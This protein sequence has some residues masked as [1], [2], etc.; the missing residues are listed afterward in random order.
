MNGVEF[1]RQVAAKLHADAVAKGFDP[2]CTYEF[3]VE[4]A[5]RRGIDVEATS[6]G[7]SLLNGGRASYIPR[8]QLI[9]HEN[10]GSVFEMAFLVA[11]EIGHA[12]FGGDVESDV[13]YKI[14]LTRTAE[15]SPIGIDRVVDYGRHQRREIQMDIFARE[16]LIPRPLIRKLYVE[17]ALS[18]SIIAER[19]GAPFDVVVQQRLDALLLPV[20]EVAAEA[21]NKVYPPN[22][23][24]KAAANHRGRAYLLEAGPGTGK[25]QTLTARVESLLDEG[26]DPR[27]ILL[28]TFSNKAAGEMAERIARKNKD[29]ATTMW[30][31]T[32]HAFGLDL[33]RRFHSELGLPKDPQLLDPTEAV[34]LL[35]HEFPQLNL[36][37]YRNL[38]DPTQIIVDILSAISRAKDEVV[39]EK[40]YTEL[41]EAMLQN[42][43]TPDD[44]ERA[45]KVLEVA[46][47]YC[48]YE[49]LKRQSH[50]VDFGDLVSVPVRLL[51]QNQAICKHL[52]MQYEHIL[53]DEYQDVNRS[54]VRLISALCGSGDNLWVVGDAKQSIYRFRGA[55]SFNMGRFGTE[56]FMGGAR[57]RLKT[58]HR[59]VREVVDIFLRFSIGMKAGGVHS[60]LVANRGLSGH[61]SELRTVDRVEQQTVA[62]ADAIEEMHRSGYAYSDQAILCTGNE[63]L[64]ILGRDLERLEV[65]VL[66]LGSLF[67]RPE[68]KDLLSFISILIDRRAVGLVRVACWD[69]FKMPIADVAL[70]LD[71]L[72]ANELK[73]CEWLKRLDVFEGL[74]DQGRAALKNLAIAFDGFDQASTPWTLLATALFDRTRIAARMV[75]SADVVDR[76]RGIAI[77]QLMNFVRI[78][79]IGSGLPIARLLDRIRSLVRLGDDRDLR[80]LPAAAQG[81]DAVRLMTIHGAKGL[82]FPVVHLTGMNAGTIPRKAPLPPCPP[83]K[84][85]IEG[86]EDDSLEIFRAAEEEEQE[87]LFYVAMSRA[88]DRLIIYA[89]T[90]MSNGQR[91]QLS[92]FLDKLGS[93]L[94]KR[95][96]NPNGNLPLASDAVEIQLSIE[97]GVLFSDQ[98]ISLY[99]S[100]PRRFFYTHILQIGGRRKT[101]AFMQMHEAVRTVI[102]AFINGN[103]PTAS[104][105]ELDLRVDEAFATEGLSEHGY[106][107][108]YKTV[109]KAMVRYFLSIREGHSS[110]TPTYLSLTIG[111]ERIIVRPDDILINSEGR[112]ILRRVRTGHRRSAE[113]DDVGAAAFILAAKQAFPDATVELVHLSDKQLYPLTFS[114]RKLKNRQKKLADFLQNIRQGHFPASPS[115][116][117]CPGCPAFFICGPTPMGPLTKKG[118][119]IYRS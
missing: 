45:E 55:S 81:I 101:M 111:N 6:P 106:A 61:H 82:E 38:Y 20:I 48:L 66:F 119:K 115:A 85:M 40:N 59:S 75:E 46:Q 9:L 72:R 17:E 74:S 87:C 34:E 71:Y 63:K 114:A 64:S 42:A 100:C 70:V 78:Q 5:R 104:D 43:L 116:L 102:Q 98:Q 62:L 69:E 84:G 51:E 73:P 112:H 58:N 93:G 117:T 91:R 31:G 96:I 113:S 65:P 53:V 49:S 90:K 2:W 99:E 22:P 44:R 37:H 13:P 50:R 25:T 94:K 14:E 18:A 56:D 52:Q 7:A 86:R 89:P 35:E 77:W 105:K 109:A 88:R 30:I 29:A 19:L 12:E 1:C 15:S 95:H 24:Q 108:D 107:N 47:V 79:S 33:M 92:P 103:G 57:G 68:I 54:S 16:F 10:I 118:Q 67:E 83:P 28:L 36:V 80:Q 4:E 11:H 39:D 26:V 60:D 110:E 97:D 21:D 23:E 32:F 8:D 41:G 27:R 76:T 3:A